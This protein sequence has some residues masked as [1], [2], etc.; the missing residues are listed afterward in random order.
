MKHIT[1]NIDDLGMHP[2]VNQAVCRLAEQNIIQSASFMSLGHVAADEWQYLKQQRIEIGLHL[3]F[4]GLAA[5]GSLKTV[6]LKSW[7]RRWQ[8]AALRDLIR[9]QLD[10]FEHQSGQIP[11]F[12]DGHQHVHQ[13]PQIREQLH[14]ELQQRY[15]HLPYLRHTRPLQNDLKSH[16]IYALGGHTAS[17]QAQTRGFR[18]NHSFGGAYAFQDSPET[19]R[20]RWKQW[21]ACAP[22]QGALLMCHPAVP[23][24]TRYDEIQAA[25]E[26]EWQWLSSPE[27]ADLCEQQQIHPQ[28]WAQLCAAPP[29][30]K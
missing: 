18:H 5:Q 22:K 8:P 19:L 16:I 4:T 30:E 24:P 1:I 15:P 28:N 11:V 20:Q 12:I 3:D 21:F 17:R 6:M 23:H 7:L 26:L 27:F 14:Q 2:A 13:F 25:R 29:T 10:A 9:R